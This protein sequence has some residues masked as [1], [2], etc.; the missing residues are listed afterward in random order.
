M[1]ILRSFRTFII[2]SLTAVLGCGNP[3]S[4]ASLK[5]GSIDVVGT[6]FTWTEG[7]ADAFGA[8]DCMTDSLVTGQAICQ[9]SNAQDQSLGVIRW[10]YGTDIGQVATLSFDQIGPKIVATNAIVYLTGSIVYAAPQ[11][12]AAM[13]ASGKRY[14]LTTTVT[15]DY[16]PSVAAT[17][18][19]LHPIKHTGYLSLFNQCRLVLDDALVDSSNFERGV[20]A[21]QRV[22]RVIRTMGFDPSAYAPYNRPLKFV[23]EMGGEEVRFVEATTEILVED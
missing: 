23:F 8:V 15:Y 1:R 7:R 16:V 14:T 19:K 10:T 2:L 5:A 21:A 6:R 9:V 17:S 12:L 11:H 22:T 18:S 3:R 13:A 20:G 4:T